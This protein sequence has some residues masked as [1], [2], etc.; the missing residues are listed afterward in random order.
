M[1]QGFEFAGF[2]AAAF[3]VHLAVVSHGP[4]G[5]APAQTAA[6]LTTISTN[7]DLS[8]LAAR[9]DRP[10]QI[11]PSPAMMTTPPVPTAAP[12]PPVQTSPTAARSVPVLPSKTP[13]TP[14]PQLD[15]RPA[16]PPVSAAAP[17]TSPRPEIRPVR[18]IAQ[19]A[20]RQTQRSTPQQA[21]S[22]SAAPARTEPRANPAALAQWGGA[23]RA[24]VERRKRYPAGTRAQGTVTMSI[25]VGSNGTL[26]RVAITRSSGHAALDRAGTAAVQRANLPAAP[27]GVRQGQHSFTLAMAFSP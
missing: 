20:P 26:A 23:I 21:Q 8:D 25:S 16:A 24:S 9:W 7:P 2:L 10:P 11:S 12:T 4:Q 22:T 3:A 27:A 13:D 5:R 1:K 19:P 6:T 14:R 17:D 15:T 18:R